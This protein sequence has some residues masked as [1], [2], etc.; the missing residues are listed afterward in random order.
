[1]RRIE[2]T[3]QLR[4]K[5]TILGA[6]SILTSIGVSALPIQA[7]S[8]EQPEIQL[9]SESVGASFSETKEVEMNVTHTEKESERTTSETKTQET[10]TTETTQETAKETSKET[11][12]NNTSNATTPETQSS[13][14]N[15]FS[16]SSRDQ[17]T[18]QSNNAP[19][20]KEASNPDNSVIKYAQN[21]TT[22]EFIQS[23]GEYAR[24]IG[25]KNDVFASV[26]IAQAILESGSGNSQL[27]S[28]PNYNLFGIK[29][30]YQGN[31]VAMKTL[32]D[33]GKG[34]MYSITA[35]F[36]SYPSYKESLEDYTKL[37]KGNETICFYQGAWKSVAKEYKVATKFLTGRYATDTRYNEKLNGLIETYHLDEFDQLKP[38][39]EKLAVSNQAENKNSQ[40]KVYQ[41]CQGDTLWDIAQKSS[42]SIEELI[43]KNNLSSAI[44]YVGQKLTIQTGTSTSNETN[45]KVDKQQINPKQ[46]AVKNDA[47][48]KKTYVVN[49]KQQQSSLFKELTVGNSLVDL[50]DQT[51]YTAQKLLRWNAE[52]T[53]PTNGQLV[54]I[55]SPAESWVNLE[56][57][58]V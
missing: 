34:K 58:G 2:K 12:T 28:Q 46:Q 27:A 15:S 54:R 57:R 22:K 38:K 19:V 37:M 18:A 24:E 11:A 50:A 14:T 8:E 33:D 43:S 5:G 40:K 51:G 23:I 16:S 17:N 39:E 9:N 6:A 47:N 56:K 29:G 52:Q 42:I 7:Y 25:Q 53:I 32:E 21:Q 36:R 31:S 4:K 45:K 10:T 1:M 55:V 49:A 26:M 35:N 13:T 3:T 41:V 44:I 20:T 48:Q 30:S